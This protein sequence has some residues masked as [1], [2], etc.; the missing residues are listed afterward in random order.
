MLHL[1][2]HWVLLLLLVAVVLVLVVPLVALGV[3]Q[4]VLVEGVV[5][6]DRGQVVVL[7]EGLEHLQALLERDFLQEP[8]RVAAVE[9][10]GVGFGSNGGRD[11]EGPVRSGAERISSKYKKK[12]NMAEK[13]SWV[14]KKK[15]RQELFCMRACRTLLTAVK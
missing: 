9:R 14:K 2:L 10:N 13:K 12:K 6:H 3:D 7:V 1:L 15:Q 11:T 5:V 8:P 4:P